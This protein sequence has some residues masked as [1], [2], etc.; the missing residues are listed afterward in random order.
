MKGGACHKSNYKT[1]TGDEENSLEL[2]GRA[3]PHGVY[4]GVVDHVH[5]QGGPRHARVGRRGRLGLGN[6]RV[7]DDHGPRLWARGK[8][9]EVDLQ[10]RKKGLLGQRHLGNRQMQLWMWR[11]VCAR[12]AGEPTREGEGAAQS[13]AVCM[14]MCVP[15]RCGQRR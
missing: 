6:G 8:R 10:Q 15:G 3:D 12:K 4:V 13:V 14:H 9:L 11:Y 1:Q 5:V 2:R 7:G